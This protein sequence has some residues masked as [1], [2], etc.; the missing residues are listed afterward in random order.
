VV[1]LRARLTSAFLIVV[2]GPVLLGAIFVAITVNSVNKSRERD[3]LDVAT[4]S[5][6]TAVA[7]TCDRL[8]AAAENAATLTVGGTRPELAQ[9]L[10]TQGRAS[11]IHI[12]TATGTDVVTTTA[13]PSPPWV[14]CQVLPANEAL[15]FVDHDFTAI[16]A[17]VQMRDPAGRNAGYVYAAQTLNAAYLR[18]LATATGADLTVVADPALST[19]TT[20]AAPHLAHTAAKLTGTDVGKAQSQY[21]RKL[22]PL[23]GQPFD[24]ALSVPIRTTTSLFAI[25]IGVVLFAALAAVGAAWALARST[26]KPLDEIAEAADRVAHGDLETRVPVRHDDEVGQLGAA[27]NRMTREMQSY[28]DALTASRDQLRGNLNVL[29]DTLSSTHDLPRILRVILASAVRATGARAGAVLLV[30]PIDGALICQ[31]A[32]GFD[33]PTNAIFEMLRL[34]SGTGVL[35]TVAATGIAECGRTNAATPLAP[36]EPRAGTYL[37]VPLAATSPVAVDWSTMDR[38]PVDNQPTLVR[39]V[40]ALYDRLGDDEFDDTDLRTVRRFAG[41]AA[42][43][44]DNV[45]LHDEAQRL[46]HTDPLTGLYNYRHLKELLSREINRSARFGHPLCVMIMDLDRFKDVNDVYGHAAGDA[47]LVEFARRISAEVR[48]VDLAFRYGGEEFVLLLPETDGIGG[49]TLAR[50]L[51]AVIRETPISVAGGVRHASGAIEPRQSPETDSSSQSTDGSADIAITVSIG[52]AVFPD[53]GTTGAQVLEAADDALYVAKA[54]GRDTFRLAMAAPVGSAAQDSSPRRADGPAPMSINV[55][56]EMPIDVGVLTQPTD[57]TPGPTDASL[58]DPPAAVIDPGRAAVAGRG[59]FGLRRNASGT[60][61][62]ASG[63]GQP[64]RQSRGR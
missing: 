13:A 17:V 38:Q 18:Q 20:T 2:I 12:E 40:L 9:T 35:G 5:L 4:T 25:V 44:V 61:G 64:P 54:A 23:P 57:S 37:A 43:A 30:D 3:R 8:Q 6:H 33:E 11:A 56:R 62:G 52:V 26:T 22:E 19:A 60:P 15:P 48:G 39:G 42:V 47:V 29:G 32:Q 53:H 58:A 51:G 10:V 49:I 55:S 16:A 50:R 27:F 34:P 24:V 63:A 59:R 21:V 46:S 1:S 41:H 14:L 31:C 45:R 7:A 36:G 28:V